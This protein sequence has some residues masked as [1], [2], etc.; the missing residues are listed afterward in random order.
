M[1]LRCYATGAMRMSK[2]SWT[3]KVTNKEVLHRMQT[4]LHFVKDM[5]KIK[6]EHVGHVLRGST[7][8]M[9]LQILEGRLQGTRMQGRPRRTWVDDI[10]NWSRGKNM[11]N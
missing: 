9:H 8:L 3:D 7:G 5:M 1:L 11:G 10:T 4:E 2:I 6:M